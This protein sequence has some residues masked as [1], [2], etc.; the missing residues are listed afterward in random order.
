[1]TDVRLIPL[2]ARDLEAMARARKEEAAAMGYPDAFGPIERAELGE[3]IERSGE[4]DGT[5]L[6]LGIQVDGR[7]A[8]EVQARQPRMGLP[9][10]VFEL[11]IDLFG[12]ADRGRGLGRT[13]LIQLL[14]RLFEHEGAHR[15]QITTDLDNEAMRRVAERLGFR[16]EGVMRSFMPTVGGARDYAMYAITGD[17]FEEAR[18]TWTS[19]S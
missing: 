15:V 16:F 4:F 1:M 14:T 13:A 6:L 19:A 2:R 17:D 5:E 3:R 11:G 12:E 7:L 8:G 10:G 9:P 18:K